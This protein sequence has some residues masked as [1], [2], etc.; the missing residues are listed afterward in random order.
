MNFYLQILLFF[1]LTVL[2]SSQTFRRFRAIPRRTANR[3]IQSRRTSSSSLLGGY[4]PF[5]QFDLDLFSQ[6]VGRSQPIIFAGD[7]PD[8]PDVYNPYEH[9]SDIDGVGYMHPGYLGGG[10]RAIRPVYMPDPDNYGYI[11]G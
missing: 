3:Y 8:M 9:L 1:T 4:S 7:A 10:Y 11:V 6:P 2:A 5:P